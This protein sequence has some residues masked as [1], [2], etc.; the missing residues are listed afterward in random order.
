MECHIDAISENKIQIQA[1]NLIL[2]LTRNDIH[3]QRQQ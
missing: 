3:R 2:N 1:A